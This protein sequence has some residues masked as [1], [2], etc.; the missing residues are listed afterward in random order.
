MLLIT[1]WLTL[2]AGYT[3]RHRSWLGASS[4]VKWWFVTE[5]GTVCQDCLAK[6]KSKGPSCQLVFPAGRKTRLECEFVLKMSN[7]LV[8][9]RSESCFIVATR[10]PVCV[11]HRKEKRFPTNTSNNTSTVPLNRINMDFF[12]WML[13][14]S[15]WQRCAWCQCDHNLN[16]GTWI[17]DDVTV[18]A[19]PALTLLHRRR[20]RRSSAVI[21]ISALSFLVSS[22]NRHD[23][24]N[25]GV[26]EARVSQSP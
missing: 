8:L 10:G 15:Q 26:H 1:W 6:W 22:Y 17:L 4:R 2:T 23:S 16:Q 24:V 25:A 3:H 13:V 9:A 14:S 5:H 12:Y 21:K 11:L 20:R 7:S 18:T 19:P